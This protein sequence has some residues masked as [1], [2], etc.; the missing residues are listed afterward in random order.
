MT[1][2]YG[3]GP[4]AR[5]LIPE[6]RMFADS[7]DQLG[8]ELVFSSQITLPPSVPTGGKVISGKNISLTC[9]RVWFLSFRNRGEVQGWDVS[10]RGGLWV[11]TRRPLEVTRGGLQLVLS[12]S[13]GDGHR[14]RLTRRA[15]FTGGRPSHGGFSGTGFVRAAITSGEIHRGRPSPVATLPGGDVHP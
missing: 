1:K 6:M 5:N 12:F 9:D 14:D 8:H 7:S 2:S 11:V 3:S 4:R 15:T 13:G 10:N